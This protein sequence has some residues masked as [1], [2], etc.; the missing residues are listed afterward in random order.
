MSCVLPLR[1]LQMPSVCLRTIQPVVSVRQRTRQPKPR[2]HTHQPAHI[3]GVFSYPSLQTS[4]FIQAGDCGAEAQQ[5][6]SG[7]QFVLWNL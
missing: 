2:P 6:S 5:S 3:C 7:G 1:V 4:V